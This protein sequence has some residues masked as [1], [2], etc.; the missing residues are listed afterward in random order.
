MVMEILTH[1]HKRVKKMTN[2]IIDGLKKVGKTIWKYLKIGGKWLKAKIKNFLDLWEKIKRLKTLINE[3]NDTIEELLTD[4][5][6]INKKLKEAEDIILAADS[7][8]NRLSYENKILED[9]AITELKTTLEAQLKLD[10]LSKKKE[11][12]AK[13]NNATGSETETED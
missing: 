13:I 7:E 9:I 10:T 11:L 4:N 3:L 12:E 5:E 6:E 2:K 8:I 1:Q